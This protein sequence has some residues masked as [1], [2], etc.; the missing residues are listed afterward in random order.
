[1]RRERKEFI[2]GYFFDYESSKKRGARRFDEY[3]EED[4][5]YEYADEFF[6]P[7]DGECGDDN[8]D[9]IGRDPFE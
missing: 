8:G 3:G 4:F 9:D 7:E 6:C 5:D 1:M 2:M